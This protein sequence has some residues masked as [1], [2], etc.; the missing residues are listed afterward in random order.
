MNK[1][2]LK[3][4]KGVAKRFKI[5]ASGKV[6]R[7][8]QNMRHLR[9]KKSKKAIRAYRIPVEVKG[10]WAKKIKKMLGIG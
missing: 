6:L 8:N 4:R 2:K 9:R 10:V 7:R 1:T 3:T 5:T